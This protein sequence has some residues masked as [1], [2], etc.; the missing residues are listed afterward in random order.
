MIIVVLVMMFAV[1]MIL[2]YYLFEK[3][4]KEY[5]IIQQSGYDKKR[6]IKYIGENKYRYIALNEFILLFTFFIYQQNVLIAFIL[7]MIVSYYN[8]KFFKLEKRRFVVKKGLVVTARVKRLIVIEFILFIVYTVLC[9]A[10]NIP[11]VYILLTYTYVLP[12][13]MLI[14]LLISE[15]FE[16]RIR[17]KFKK[18]ATDRLKANENL[19][20][21]GITGSF[22]KTS[23]KN[24]IYD[25][26]S[27]FEPTLTT[28]ASYNTPNGI[29]ITVNNELSVLHRN[30]IAEMGAYYPGEIKELT[31]ICNPSI[32]IVSSIGNQHL[33]TFKTVE[34]IQKTKME[35]IENLAPNGIA[36]LN[37]DEEYIRNYQIKRNDL[38]IYKYGLENRNVD[39]YA[40]NIE[41]HIG[42]MIFTIVDNVEDE[43]YQI[44]TK[45]LGKYNVYNIMAAYAVA[46]VKGIK[47]DEIIQLLHKVNAV[48]HRLELKHI[49]SDTYIIDDAFNGNIRGITEGLDIINRYRDLGYQAIIITPGLI[50]LGKEQQIANEQIAGLLRDKVDYG[51][52]V[53]DYN[54]KYYSNILSGE[55][56]IIF[57]D[58]FIE[59]YHKA[60]SIN[61][62]KVI[63]IA[64]DLPDKFN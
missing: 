60:M 56:K 27:N 28:P 23:I 3:T 18:Q 30:F 29:S 19:L 25:V 55:E 15:P 40:K 36:I 12:C 20:V 37:Y 22:G 13:F 41:Y 48:E 54:K 1:W 46:K 44:E 58:N 52:I 34:N 7:V 10:L 57:D 43:E 31:D 2:S 4:L 42:K 59:S 64:N 51:F 33:E 61:G 11:I 35:L 5:Q 53:G 39:V 9:A 14:G 8:I 38:S 24:I 16:K 21:I 49:D 63:L 17:E 32:G 6:Y 26:L 62:K 47:C 45:L 50:D